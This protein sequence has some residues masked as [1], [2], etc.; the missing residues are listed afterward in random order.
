[1]KV[2]IKAS[3]LSAPFCRERLRANDKN[4]RQMLSCLQLLEYET[5]LN[6]FAH[7]DLVGNQDSRPIRSS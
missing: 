3:H 6:G 5:R 7:A 4:T 1:M 2:F